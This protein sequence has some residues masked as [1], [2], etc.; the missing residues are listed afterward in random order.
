MC[1]R[2]PLTQVWLYYSNITWG[3]DK[4]TPGLRLSF[5]LAAADIGLSTVRIYVEHIRGNDAQ[6][7]IYIYKVYI[8]TQPEMLVGI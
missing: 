1:Q 6:L 8:A 5:S 4:S 2:W 7:Y 3:R